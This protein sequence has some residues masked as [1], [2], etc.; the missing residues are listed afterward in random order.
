MFSNFYANDPTDPVV[1]ASVSACSGFKSMMGIYLNGICNAV[2]VSV[3]FM[4]YGTTLNG[5]GYVMFTN[6]SVGVQGT[7]LTLNQITE[8]PVNLKSVNLPVTTYNGRP[9]TIT[10]YKKIKQLQ[11]KSEL[12]PAAYQF[13]DTQGPGTACYFMVGFTPTD[14]SAANTTTCAFYVRITYYC[15]LFNRKMTVATIAE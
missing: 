5:I 7:A 11:G 8:C 12:E 10:Y 6:S 2:K 3:T 15:K 9:R 1:G 13:T 14:S 4:N